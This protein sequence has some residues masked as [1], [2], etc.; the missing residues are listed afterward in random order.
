ML[1]GF[2]LTGNQQM[3]HVG[4]STHFRLVFAGPGRLDAGLGGEEDSASESTRGGRWRRAGAGE[5]EG[6][7]ES[8]SSFTAFTYA[9]CVGGGIEGARGGMIAFAFGVTPAGGGGEASRSSSSAVTDS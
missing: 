6:E 1:D 2:G 3:S 9:P 5:T 4:L 7:E 8:F